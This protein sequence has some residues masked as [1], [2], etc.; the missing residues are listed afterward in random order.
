MHFCRS[1]LA[2]LMETYLKFFLKFPFI[3]FGKCM[4]KTS[5]LE[6]FLQTNKFTIHHY[7]LC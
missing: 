2:N 6:T 1:D 7:F 3:V 5:A 4:A